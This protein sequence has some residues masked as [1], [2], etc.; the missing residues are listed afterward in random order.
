MN[1]RLAFNTV[2]SACLAGL[3]AAGCSGQTPAAAPEATSAAPALNTPPAATANAGEAVAAPAQDAATR[4]APLVRGRPGRVFIFAS[5][6]DNCELLPAPQVNIDRGPRMG[7]I[8]LK[9]NQQTT[10]AASKSGKCLGAPTT[11][12]GVYYTA[13]DDAKGADTFALT[14]RLASG[15][16][17]TRSFTVTIAE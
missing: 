7:Q 13:R 6:G 5:V 4:S 17:M 3:L 12:T 9:L 14:A 16:T 15:E 2:I 11:G 8:T 1:P 10:I